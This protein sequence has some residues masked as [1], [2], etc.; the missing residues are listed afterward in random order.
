MNARTDLAIECCEEISS[1]AGIAKTETAT[2]DIKVTTV[3]ITTDSA[4]RAAGKEKGKYV[5]AEF[6][7]F[8]SNS[9]DKDA[10]DILTEE[11]KKMLPA[12]GTVLVIGLGN[13]EITPDAIGPQTAA[14]ILATR[15]I[16]GEFARGVGLDG[17]RPVAVLAPG[18]L[19]QTGIETTEII[20]STVDEI[21]P[22]AVIVIDALAARDLG[23]L[24]NTVQ[25]SNT[26]IT[27]GSG[28]GNN[29]KEVSEKTLGVP[30]FSIGVPTVT[31]AATLV[32]ELTGKEVS[33]SQNMIV[34]QREIDLLIDRSSELIGHAV[35]CALQPN[36]S[37]EILADIV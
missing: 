6:M 2:G 3:E 9:T 5:T 18:V 28:V 20:K 35:N 32:F 29:R 15:H 22:S 14:K 34:T 13:R 36:I 25:I 23:R 1:D 33:S 19:G 4:A 17:L 24:G 37:E 10:H 16:E 12:K 31:D 27:P 7:P 26:G 30:V 21:H 8:M 11:L